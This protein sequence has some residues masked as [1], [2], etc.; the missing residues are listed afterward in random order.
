MVT[1][2]TEGKGAISY[3]LFALRGLKCSEIRPFLMFHSPATSCGSSQAQICDKWHVSEGVFQKFNSEC[4]SFCLPQA[5]STISFSQISRDFPITLL[6]WNRGDAAEWCGRRFFVNC[7]VHICHIL[8]FF[9]FIGFLW[10]NLLSPSWAALITQPVMR[11]TCIQGF[12]VQVFWRVSASKN[13]AVTMI[14]R[15]S[16][17]FFS[18]VTGLKTSNSL[19]KHQVDPSRSSQSM[20]M[21]ASQLRSWWGFP[22]NPYG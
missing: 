17:G 19:G 11:I 12:T 18:H 2:P 7:H 4:F 10:F 9:E 20:A 8:I 22:L 15:G 1:Y 3:I 6:W 14:S 21:S 13:V 5:T 16:S